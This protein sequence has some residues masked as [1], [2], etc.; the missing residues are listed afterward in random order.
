MYNVI[1]N[2]SV[3]WFWFGVDDVVTFIHG[4]F[5]ADTIGE[6]V[7]GAKLKYNLDN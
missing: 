7:T 3:V 2:T 5:K 1:L 4:S 6:G